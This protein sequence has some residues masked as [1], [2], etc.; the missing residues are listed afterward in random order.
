[1]YAS[2]WERLGLGPTRDIPA[3]KRAYALQLRTT[4]P[5]DD[6]QAYQALREA[7]ERAQYWARYVPDDEEL[8]ADTAAEDDD[9]DTDTED[10]ADEGAA[11]EAL[12]PGPSG[13]R[14]RWDRALRLSGPAPGRR[15]APTRSVRRCGP[16]P[17]SGSGPA[18][19][20]PRHN[21]DREKPRA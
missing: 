12:A 9:A 5:D 20:K 4:R 2:D 14:N 10:R 21:R 1:M 16:I 3:I 7:Y 13:S 18:S 19:G 6:A 15:C 11:G 8:E 17:S